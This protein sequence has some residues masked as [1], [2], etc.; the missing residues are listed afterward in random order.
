MATKKK[1]PR[2]RAAQDATLINIRALKSQ[3]NTLRA[4]YPLWLLASIHRD[5][6]EVENRLDSM[7]LR[8][9]ALETPASPIPE[10]V[11]GT[12]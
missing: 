12:E 11:G 6:R 1:K 4:R 5:I 8:L 10:S 2:N 9:L 7:H 3:M